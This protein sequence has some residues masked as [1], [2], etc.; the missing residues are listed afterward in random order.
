MEQTHTKWG[1][2]DGSEWSKPLPVQAEC[3]G[4]LNSGE[5][6]GMSGMVI[7]PCGS[8]KTRVAVEQAVQCSTVLFLSYEM[9]GVAQFVSALKEHTNIP[10]KF[11]NTFNG[12]TKDRPNSLFCFLSTHYSMLTAVSSKSGDSRRILDFVNET[13]W[14]L[15]VCDECHHCP[16]NCYKEIIEDLKSHSTR[17]LGIT[18]TPIRKLSKG[19]ETQLE[20]ASS[21]ERAMVMEDVFD[22]IGPVLFSKSWKEMDEKK[23]I[24]KLTFFE[25]QTE[26][27]SKTQ[28]A[29]EST[30]GNTRAYVGNLPTTKM[31]AIWNLTRMHMLRDQVGIVF[32]DHVWQTTEIAAMLGQGW[33]TLRGAS[34]DKEEA[35]ASDVATSI[36][37]RMAI[38]DRINKDDPTVHGIVATRVADAALDIH[39]KRFCYA[40]SV[41]ASSSEST[42]AQRAGRII[43]NNPNWEVQKQANYYDLV[44][45]G[46]QD[47]EASEQRRRFVESEACATPHTS[48]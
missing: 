28:L 34:D 26:M 20:S 35:N 41:D 30:T 4:V 43:R 3:E 24:A 39:S 6:V 38:K 16:S 9:S 27:D 45:P 47:E 15:V 21:E 5:M 48:R 32:C 37:A 12:S 2:K 14:D 13:H 23:F 46:T 25:V 29:Y 7:L 42:N 18:A 19:L 8:G 10:H 33:F 11:I 22:F 36:E 40:I 17:I 44:T 31:E 1:F